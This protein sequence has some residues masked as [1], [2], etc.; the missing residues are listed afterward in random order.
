MKNTLKRKVALL[1][2]LL[3]IS[4]VSLENQY[5]SFGQFAKANIYFFANEAGG[6]ENCI[7]SVR[8]DTHSSLSAQGLSIVIDEEFVHYQGS[9]GACED[10]SIWYACR[11]RC[12]PC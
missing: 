2:A 12:V 3:F 4:M 1:M 5:F 10:A 11:T 9:Q 7:L 6:T 8:K